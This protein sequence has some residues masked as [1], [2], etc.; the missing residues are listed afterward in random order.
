LLNFA[1]DCAS[2]L[3]FGLAAESEAASTVVLGEGEGEGSETLV[4]AM[5]LLSVLIENIPV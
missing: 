1:F 5:L 3:G 2:E 4:D